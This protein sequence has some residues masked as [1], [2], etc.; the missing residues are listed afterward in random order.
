VPAG[1]RRY[2]FTA[3]VQKLRRL[4]TGDVPMS[5]PGIVLQELS[6]GVRTADKFQRLRRLMEGLPL[7]WR[8]EQHSRECGWDFEFVPT[9]RELEAC[10]QSNPTRRLVLAVAFAEGC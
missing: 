8:L 5:A 7:Y 3:A 1:R 6:S 10:E 9:G 2:F 4:V